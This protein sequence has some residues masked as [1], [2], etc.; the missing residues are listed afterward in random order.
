MHMLQLPTK[1]RF[2]S[3]SMRFIGIYVAVAACGFLVSL[4]LLAQPLPA[5]LSAEQRDIGRVETHIQ[6]YQQA[7]GVVTRL[8]RPLGAETECTGI[9]YFPNSSRPV[10]WH[11]APANSCDLHCDVN[12]PVGGCR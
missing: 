1:S 2:E 3:K 11:C 12:P 4:P 10:S 8:S 5:G 7:V 6:K 9:C